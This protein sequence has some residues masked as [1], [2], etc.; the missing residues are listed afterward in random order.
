MAT[1]NP[2]IFVPPIP[3]AAENTHSIFDDP[4]VTFHPFFYPYSTPP[5]C[6]CSQS[7][8]FRYVPAWGGFC[9]Y[10]IAHE[11]LW[12]KFVLGSYYGDPDCWWIKDG[13]TYLFK[14]CVNVQDKRHL[15][16]NPVW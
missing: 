7:D 5:S 12:K 15:R 13:V 9:A 2:T 3:F 16:I 14:R 10:G 8:P 4:P 6:V 1:T 11:E